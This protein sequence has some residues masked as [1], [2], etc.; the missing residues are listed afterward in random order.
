M[1]DFHYGR[2]EFILYSEY[3]GEEWRENL[4]PGEETY[5]DMID[6]EIHPEDES[7]PR[8]IYEISIV[9]DSKRNGWPDV[10]CPLE[11]S[12]GLLHMGDVLS[13][14]SEYSMT[15]LKPKKVVAILKE[16]GFE[17]SSDLD[18]D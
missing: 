4:D 12:A 3:Y 15:D 18:D 17:D 6:L 13:R 11:H 2:K 9:W 14:F 16:C 10:L 7:A 8:R 5:I 1:A